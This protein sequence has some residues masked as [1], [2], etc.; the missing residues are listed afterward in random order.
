MTKF[1][2]HDFGGIRIALSNMIIAEV[3]AALELLPGKC[4]ETD[5]TDFPLCRVVVSGIDD[6]KPMDASVTKAWLADEGKLYIIAAVHGVSELFKEDDT[7]WL[8]I[9][10]FGYLIDQIAE[11]VEGDRTVN[12]PTKTVLTCDI[13]PELELKTAIEKTI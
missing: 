7:D 4:V 5:K 3:K 1:I 2:R 12:L 11:Q 9:T 13:A 10:D 6:Y 8:D